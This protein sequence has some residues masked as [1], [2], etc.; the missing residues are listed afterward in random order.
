MGKIAGTPRLKGKGAFKETE[1]E[2]AEIWSED[3]WG[4]AGKNFRECFSIFQ[5]NETVRH[6]LWLNTYGADANLGGPRGKEPE[7]RE[8]R[9]C[10][11]EKS[12]WRPR[13]GAVVS[14]SLSG[15]ERT[16]RDVRCSHMKVRF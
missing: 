1:N 6:V 14:R 13:S 9:C 7:G 3:S 16:G 5:H 2:T 8:Q 4:R 10:K 15:S 12:K 11:H